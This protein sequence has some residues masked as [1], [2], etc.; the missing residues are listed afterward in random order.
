MIFEGSDQKLVQT[1]YK[2]IMKNV[3]R[4]SDK[5]EIFFNSRIRHVEIRCSISLI[6]NNQKLQGKIKKNNR[7]NAVLDCQQILGVASCNNTLATNG[8]QCH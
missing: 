8:N 3:A 1:R 2:L 6:K 5:A 4:Y 7:R